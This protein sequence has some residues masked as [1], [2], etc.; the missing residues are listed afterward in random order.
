MIDL[1]DIAI[2]NLEDATG[3]EA[4]WEEGN[5]EDGT[6]LITNEGR[7]IRLY[8]KVKEHLRLHQ[9]NLILR[10]RKPE[11][12]IAQ[13]IYNKEKEILKAEHIGYIEANG[14][15][16]IKKN[17]LFLLIE[18]KKTEKASKEKGN[19]AFTKTGLKVIFQLLENKELVNE[20]QREIARKANVALGNIPLVLN[21][22]VETGFLLKKNKNQYVWEDRDALL[23]RWIAAYEVT[24]KPQLY[25]GAFKFTIN[26]EEIQLDKPLTLWGGEPAAD[27]LTNHLRPEKY[28]L[29]TQE[30]RNTLITKY[31]IRPDTNG[32]IKVYKQFWN[33][34]ENMK[35]A[36]PFLVYAD[37]QLEGGKRNLETANMI[38]D[39]YIKPKL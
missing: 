5:H 7:E 21:G 31:R 34:D 12:V 15:M 11:I 28:M 16:E 26:W 9:I 13:K 30:N 8:A 24:L 33:Q 35:T 4:R 6:L 37:L 19:R 20:A 29:Y 14:N 39:E 3:L 36:P 22:L 2:A 23:R 1:V 32:E 17:G 27:L 38:Y 25:L 10:E 18:T